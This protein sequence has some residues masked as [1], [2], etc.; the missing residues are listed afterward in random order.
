M[1]S[2]FTKELSRSAI[3]K[4]DFLIRTQD[5]LMKV[6]IK[7]NEIHLPDMVIRVHSPTDFIAKKLYTYGVWE[8]HILEVMQHTIQPGDVVLDVGANI[9][10]HTIHF[11]RWVGT[12]GMVMAF[13]PDPANI[14]LLKSNLAR[15]N[16]KNVQVFPVALSDR[17][18]Q[19]DLYRFDNNMMCNSLAN[20][21]G[22]SSSIKVPVHKTA[23]F[24]DGY[25]I[26]FAKIDVEGYE[27]QVIHGMDV[28][29]NNMVVEFYPKLLETAGSSPM[30]WINEM[31]EEKGY[32]L[33]VI[34]ES[35]LVETSATDLRI[36][37]EQDPEVVMNLL[38]RRHYV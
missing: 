26:A 18:D 33:S 16:C 31:I 34:E 14:E 20:V 32:V 13:E 9:G 11:S 22:S 12:S 27:P 10:F 19:K 7:N 36:R 29:P 2:K 1:L 37:I 17:K 30:L 21:E 5:L 3:G 4:W 23:E 24:T 25:K 6:L 28:L 38:A 15:N 8:K 35:G